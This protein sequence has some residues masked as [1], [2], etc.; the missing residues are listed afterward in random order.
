M[1]TC[2]NST[3]N[4]VNRNITKVIFYEIISKFEICVSARNNNWKMYLNFSN[5]RNVYLS[6]NFC[7]D[8]RTVNNIGVFADRR[9]LIFTFWQQRVGEGG[10]V[11][12]AL[13][14]KEMAAQTSASLSPSVYLW[15]LTDRQRQR[16]RHRKTITN[17][18]TN[19]LWCFVSFYSALVMSCH[20][21]QQ[22]QQPL[23][24]AFQ[25]IESS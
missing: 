24:S 17:T 1:L 22:I 10:L 14:V 13:L 23:E 15:L 8:S 7:R 25:L 16:Q 19:N 11:V 20:H 4:A 9:R 12:F 21:Q 6:C 3:Q 18:K 5:Q 2:Q